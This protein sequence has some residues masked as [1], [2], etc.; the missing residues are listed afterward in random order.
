[1]LLGLGEE[2]LIGWRQRPLRREDRDL[3][4]RL[5]ASII[6]GRHAPPG[7]AGQVAH[8]LQDRTPAG[9]PQPSQGLQTGGPEEGGPAAPAREGHADQDL[10]VR[11][12]RDAGR[13]GSRLGDADG[14]GRGAP[15]QH[16]RA[17]KHDAGSRP[18]GSSDHPLT[19]PHVRLLLAGVRRRHGRRFSAM[20]YD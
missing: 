20:A 11:G 8:L 5:P 4:G 9:G 3:P 10:P 13:V 15:R 7:D 2:R 6:G 17:Q 16:E 19:A 1:M 12:R 18:E 14:D